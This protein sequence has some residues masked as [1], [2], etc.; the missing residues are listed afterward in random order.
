MPDD[1]ATQIAKAR[2]VAD[3]LRPQWPEKAAE[4]E[5]AIADLEGGRRESLK[6]EVGVKFRLEKYAGD[7]VPGAVPVEV[8]EG[9]G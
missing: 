1:K 3:E 6:I 8:I 4:I 5:A 7:Y 9:Q 2:A